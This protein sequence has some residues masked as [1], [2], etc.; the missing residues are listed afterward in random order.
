MTD[1]SFYSDEP[2]RAE[3]EDSFPKCIYSVFI[4]CLLCAMHCSRLY[5]YEGE[6]VEFL[7]SSCLSPL[8]ELCT[9]NHESTEMEALYLAFVNGE[10]L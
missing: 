10:E 8:T 7:C 1:S 9:G 5:G 2:R 6:K 3:K 4:R